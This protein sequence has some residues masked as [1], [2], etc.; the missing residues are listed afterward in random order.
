MKTNN[1]FNRMFSCSLLSML[2]IILVTSCT[3]QG[4]TGSRSISNIDGLGTNPNPLI[5][6]NELDAAYA[7]Q[8]FSLLTSE[9]SQLFGKTFSTPSDMVD[10]VQCPSTIKDKAEFDKYSSYKNILST[11]YSKYSAAISKVYLKSQDSKYTKADVEVL[12]DVADF[13]NNEKSNVLSSIEK[14]EA[15]L[16]SFVDNGNN[17]GVTPTPTFTF[18]PTPTPIPTASYANEIY[19]ATDN[20]LS[21]SFDGGTTFSNKTTANGLKSNNVNQVVVDD[22]GTIY[23]GTESGIAISKN[24][25]TNFAVYL[26]GY[27]VKSV[28]VVDGSVYAGV[29]G[30]GLFIGKEVNGTYEFKFVIATVPS[31][32]TYYVDTVFVEK[33]SI[34]SY[35]VLLGHSDKRWG[36]SVSVN[37]GVDFKYMDL[38]PNGVSGDPFDNVMRISKFNN[39]YFVGTQGGLV[40]IDKDNQIERYTTYNGLGGNMVRTVAVDDLGTIYACTQNG[41]S[42][43]YDDNG[44]MKFE[45]NTLN[46]ANANYSHVESAALD[47]AGG[48]YVGTWGQGIFASKDRGKSFKNILPNPLD[49][50]GGLGSKNVRSIFVK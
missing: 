19:A 29:W 24:G 10:L 21:I 31:S 7:G 4:R 15:S 39:V 50:K 30:N 37:N 26:S 40:T 36:I 23:A 34:G 20:G 47:K 18:T 38:R 45:N 49:P 22:K 1:L 41:L 42:K 2:M 46:K 25:G 48:V 6:E 12:N 32:N 16:G 43:S 27:K 33:N 44:I 17:G 11:G 35:N 3:G 9:L 8:K 13:L 28:K 5:F 14:C